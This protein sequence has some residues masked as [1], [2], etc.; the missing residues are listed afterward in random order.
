MCRWEVEDGRAVEE[1]DVHRFSLA[2]DAQLEFRQRF[3]ESVELQVSAAEQE[4]RE[5]GIVAFLTFAQA[6][7]GLVE[8]LARQ[9][10]LTLD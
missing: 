7:D 5:P 8:A 2:L 1:K 3:R 6:L 4:M 10:N 9:S